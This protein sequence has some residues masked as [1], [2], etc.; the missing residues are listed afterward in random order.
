MRLDIEER[1]GRAHKYLLLIQDEAQKRCSLIVHIH[2]RRNRG[3]LTFE[4]RGVV[5]AGDGGVCGEK[6]MDR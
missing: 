3:A 2:K 5:Y 1:G 4:K 6:C